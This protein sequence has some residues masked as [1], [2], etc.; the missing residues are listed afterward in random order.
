M[1]EDATARKI[2]I[3]INDTTNIAPDAEAS[4]FGGNSFNDTN[5]IEQPRK[6]VPH[7]ERAENFGANFTREFPAVFHHGFEVKNKMMV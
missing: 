4:D 6:I 7:L 5:S 2:R 3:Q 1:N